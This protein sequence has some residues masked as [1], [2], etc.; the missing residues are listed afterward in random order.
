MKFLEEFRWFV[1]SRLLQRIPSL[2]TVQRLV[3][4]LYPEDRAWVK[5]GW[6]FEK[7]V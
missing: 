2:N 5:Y 7:R 3:W 4:L 6:N 1:E